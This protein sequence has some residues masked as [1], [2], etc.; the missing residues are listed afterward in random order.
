MLVELNV[1]KYNKVLFKTRPRTSVIQT[2]YKK[3]EAKMAENDG[4]IYEGRFNTIPQLIRV[5]NGLYR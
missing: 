2:I 5:S 4:Q 3:S 1:N